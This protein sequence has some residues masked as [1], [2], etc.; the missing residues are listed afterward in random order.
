MGLLESDQVDRIM[1]SFASAGDILD[2]YEPGR[3]SG[4][5]HFFTATQDKPD[6]VAFRAAWADHVD[7]VVHNVDVPTHHLGMA[8]SQSL[9]IIGPAVD[10]VLVDLASRDENNRQ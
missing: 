10:R 4:D 2:G 6:P 8:D 1:E 9:A 3:F 5:V 7:G